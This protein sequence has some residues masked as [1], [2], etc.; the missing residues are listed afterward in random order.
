M[1]DISKTDLFFIISLYKQT[2]KTLLC[3]KKLNKNVSGK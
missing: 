2:K 3:Y 1:P